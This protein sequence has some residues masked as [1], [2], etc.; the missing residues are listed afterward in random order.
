LAEVVV[1]AVEEVG[2]AAVAEPEEKA[3]EEEEAKAEVVEVEAEAEKKEEATVTEE[4]MEEVNMKE[5]EEEEDE[6]LEEKKEPQESK[7]AESVTNNEPEA[8]DQ[9]EEDNPAGKFMLLDRLSKFIRQEDKPLNAVL[10]GYFAKLF[11]LL[12]NRKQKSLLPYVF[13]PES[14]FIES[15]LYHVYQKSLSELITKFLNIQEESTRF[16]EN[17]AKLVKAKQVQILDTLVEK[18]GPDSSEEDNLNASSIL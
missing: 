2:V 10:S 15:L 17:I 12:I 4:K 9:V 14:D 16:D 3:P 7:V 13:S 18:L 11:T 8:E 6:V 1:A 5:P